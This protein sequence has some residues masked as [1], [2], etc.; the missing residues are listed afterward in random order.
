MMKKI[1]PV[2]DSLLGNTNYC[3]QCRRVVRQ[4]LMRN[5]DYYLNEM[6]PESRSDGEK[7]TERNAVLQQKPVPVLNQSRTSAA[8]KPGKIYIY[9]GIAAGIFLMLVVSAFFIGIMLAKESTVDIGGNWEEG[10][11]EDSDYL[12]FEEEDVKSA[13]ISCTGYQHFPVNGKEAAD[14]MNRFFIESHFEYQ[15]EREEAYSDNYGFEEETGV[16]T[17]YQTLESFYF[18]D[19]VAEGEAAGGEEYVYQY[20]DIDYDTATGELHEYSSFLNSQEASFAFLEEFLRVVES[21]ALI[22]EEESS[23]SGIM[24]K[25]KADFAEN[26]EG[27]VL[28]GLFYVSIYQEEDGVSVFVECGAPVEIEDQEL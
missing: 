3:R 12:E 7:Q 22:P 2:C 11:Y 10:Y 6:R 21:L 25:A 20:A 18:E 28:E 26:G 17:Y 4:P 23:V 13:G 14:A 5:A 16:V 15:V 19:G 8:R 1:C 9:G 24:E 27:Y